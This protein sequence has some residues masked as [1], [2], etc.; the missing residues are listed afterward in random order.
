[1]R[2]LLC[3]VL[4]LLIAGCGAQPT[5]RL[6]L[7]DT[8]KR[9]D[10]SQSYQW[11]QYVHPEQNVDFEI[12]NGF[13]EARAWDGGFMWVDSP[14]MTHDL[15][16]EAEATQLS[17]YRNNA[18]GVMCRAQPSDTNGDGYYF[19]ISGDGQY[20]IRRGAVDN[21]G[22]L[23]PW[24]YSS[25]IHQDKGLNRIRAVCIGSY[26]AL[27]VNDQFVAETRDDYFSSGYAGLTVAV[28]KGGD[29][30]VVFDNLYLIN[31]S[32]AK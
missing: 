4:A 27:Y 16:V 10:F 2:G 11:E 29:A 1:M 24:T 19:L 26:L 22:A 14:P 21:I 6:V 23:I 3:L 13:Y 31:A 8:I 30:D 32:L 18:Y 25:A 9:V 15:A 17:T 28:V 20:T 7:G 12:K 5:E